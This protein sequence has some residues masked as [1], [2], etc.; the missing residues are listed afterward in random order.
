MARA[1]KQKAE[2]SREKERQ[3]AEVKQLWQTMKLAS[4]SDAPEDLDIRD[5]NLGGLF[6]THQSPKSKG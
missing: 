1:D 5:G 2:G 3:E 4:A 6:T